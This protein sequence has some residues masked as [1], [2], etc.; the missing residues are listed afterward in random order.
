MNI[1]TGTS[2]SHL[3]FKILKSIEKLPHF[4]LEIP[5]GNRFWKGT[6]AMVRQLNF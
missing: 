6:M 1:P 3:D 4:Q 2:W 5:G